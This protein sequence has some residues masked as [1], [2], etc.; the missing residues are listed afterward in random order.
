MDFIQLVADRSEGIPPRVLQPIDGYGHFA[1]F[2]ICSN[3]NKVFTNF[4]HYTGA[5]YLI[6]ED[7][8]VHA[9]NETCN[10]TGWQHWIEIFKGW[11]TLK[12]Q[13]RSIFWQK[14]GN[15]KGVIRLDVVAKFKLA[16]HVFFVK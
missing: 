15:Q 13:S 14:I 7:V 16:H 1:F 12:I 4:E 2:H 9:D 3:Q 5:P 10:N 6:L 11:S 8:L